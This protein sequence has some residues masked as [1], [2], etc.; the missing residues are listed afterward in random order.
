MVFWSI[1]SEKVTFT[2]IYPP[3]WILPMTLVTYGK[4]V[5]WGAV[6]V[7][8]D[9]GGGGGGGGV[10]V[11]VVVVVVDVVAVVVVWE[12]VEDNTSEAV[13]ESVEHPA[14][15]QACTLNSKVPEALPGR[16]I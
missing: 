7:V 12:E 13:F 15:L 10:V 9:G 2:F 11:V 4:T 14:L 16:P 6:V 1:A 3:V 5:S 8:Y